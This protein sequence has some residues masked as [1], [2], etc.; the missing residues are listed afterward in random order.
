MDRWMWAQRFV[1]FMASR[2]LL[3][4][5]S[6][7]VSGFVKKEVY[8]RNYENVEGSSGGGGGRGGRSKK[9]KPN[10]NSDTLRIYLKKIW[11]SS[12]GGGAGANAHV[13]SPTPLNML[14][15]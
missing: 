11:K 2:G 3:T 1:H 8:N 14:L 13:I 15:I 6:V 5:P 12:G 10:R 7:F 9:G 4:Y